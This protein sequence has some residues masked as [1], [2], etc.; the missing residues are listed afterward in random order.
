[1]GNDID[2]ITSEDFAKDV[3]TGITISQSRADVDTKKIGLI[4][5]SEGGMIAP[6]VAARKRD[7]A[8]IVLLAGPGISGEEIWDY[9]MARNMIK[10]GL[11]ES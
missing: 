7:V 9:Q 4:G 3:E 8:F 5:H 11:N 2:K 10:P 1:M 6:M